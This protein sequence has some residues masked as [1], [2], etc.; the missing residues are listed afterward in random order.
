MHLILR[1]LAIYIGIL[2]H[3]IRS[4]SNTYKCYTL[5]CWKLDEQE[6]ALFLFF[7]NWNSKGIRELNTYFQLLT[8]IYTIW[9]NKWTWERKTHQS[10][11]STGLLIFEF[12]VWIDKFQQ[13]TLVVVSFQLFDLV[14]PFKKRFSDYIRLH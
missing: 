10:K 8:D 12:S 6:S 2:Y 14:F 7:L 9:Y 5:L 13:M 1:R 4:A 11:T 3:L